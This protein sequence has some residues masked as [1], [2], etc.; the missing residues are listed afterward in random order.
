MFCVLAVFGLLATAC[1]S[2]PTDPPPPTVPPE[3]EDG[4]AEGYK[5]EVSA[6]PDVVLD[7]D[8]CPARPN[9]VIYTANEF[10]FTGD[11]DELER[12]QLVFEEIAVSGDVTY[13]L[14]QG[15]LE[16]EE[17]LQNEDAFRQHYFW[18]SPIHRGHPVDT[19]EDPDG[20]VYE[21]ASDW[22]ESLGGSVAI[23]D[24]IP[25]GSDIAEHGNFI[26]G[27]LAR[28]G[29]PSEL[30]KV[31]TLPGTTDSIF[32]READLIRA[33][34]EISPDQFSAVNLS[35]G[36]YGCPDHKPG[37]LN[38]I[39]AGLGIDIV[40]SA[41]N[42]GTG[43]ETY[44]AAEFIAVG[45]INKSGELSCFSNYGPWVDYWVVGE[46][47]L[48]DI[49]GADKTWSGTSFA[50]PQVAAQIDAGI[51]ATATAPAVVSD[52]N[53]EYECS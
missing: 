24:A 17:F 39:L 10:I 29:T 47:V 23:I 6:L 4:P 40:A 1:P 46:E 41:G 49:G 7:D 18:M 27:M 8:L 13:Y 48:G 16:E 35:L 14:V 26:I 15:S 34:N 2:E 9:P 44:P 22:G 21:P 33:V 52:P 12:K 5:D 42:D 45:S 51:V 3:Q 31:E 20:D 30:F 37:A 36:T 38:R 19:P 11:P 32:F 50:A 53:P 43:Q 28:L 25:D